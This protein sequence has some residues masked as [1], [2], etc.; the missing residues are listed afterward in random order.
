MLT[1]QKTLLLLG[2]S[3][4]IGPYVVQEA[5]KAGWKVKALVRSEDSAKRISM[6]GAETFQG[7]AEHPDLWVSE[8]VGAQVILDL[9]QPRHPKR[10]GKKQVLA[11]SKE[12]LKFTNALVRSLHSL[13]RDQQPILISVS[14]I[15]D[16]A[17]DNEG[18]ISRNSLL[19]NDDYGFSSV[20]VPVRRLIEQSNIKAVFANLGTVYGPGKAFSESIF[21]QI[22]KGKWKNFGNQMALIHVQDAA[23][24]L[25]Y[26]VESEPSQ[27]IG[28]S[29]VLTDG[30]PVDMKSFFGL[31]ASYMGVPAPGRIPRWLASMAAGRALVETMLCDVPI[32]SSIFSFHNFQLVYPSYREGLPATLAAL[33]YGG[34]QSGCSDNKALKR[35][36]EVFI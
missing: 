14:G 7:N 17:P 20:G 2:S 9:A 12:K 30:C 23:R 33:D 3:G 6:L 34:G 1:N 36:L 18:Y 16:L 4:F 31:V 5:M 35:V 28:K 13:K 24:G 21:P 26:I 10:V 11:A 29:F 15:D 19:R 8:I 27:I 32:K 22:A 25:M